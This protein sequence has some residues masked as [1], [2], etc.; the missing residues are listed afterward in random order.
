MILSSLRGISSLLRQLCFVL[1]SFT[2]MMWFA[3]ALQA[4]E[5]AHLYRV[6]VPVSSQQFKERKRASSDA[7]ARVVQR[8]TGDTVALDEPLV[9]DA[10]Q[11]SERYI[12]QFSYY[13]SAAK[14][15]KG[16]QYVRLLFD[17]MLVKQLLRQS[18]QP[19]WGSNRPMLMAWV[20]PA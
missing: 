11:N 16:D 17:E 14:S 6:D 8:I 15:G 4:T 1:L 18:K 13:L 9:K 3:G 19:I 10:L 5:V 2:P 20:G 7:L 12:Q